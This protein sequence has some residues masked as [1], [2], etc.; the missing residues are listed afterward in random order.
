MKPRWM[1]TN[2]GESAVAAIS[3]ATL[4]RYEVF[5]QMALSAR[6]DAINALPLG[7]RFYVLYYRHK[8]SAKVLQSVTGRELYAHGITTRSERVKTPGAIDLEI[9]ELNEDSAV[10]GITRDDQK[11][12][13]TLHFVREDGSWKLN[14]LPTIEKAS[15]YFAAKAKENGLRENEYLFGEIF[16]ATDGVVPSSI[17]TPLLPLEN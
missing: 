10:G 9:V 13:A 11:T 8:Y 16:R 7:E 4:D 17:W 12:G 3:K 15:S 1:P 2:D 14:M 5:Q 6:A